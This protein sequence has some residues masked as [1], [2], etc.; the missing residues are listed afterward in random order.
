MSRRSA[1]KEEQESFRTKVLELLE[2]LKNGVAIKY[3]NAEVELLLDP[4][5]DYDIMAKRVNNSITITLYSK[6]AVCTVRARVDKDGEWKVRSA[7]CR[8]S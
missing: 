5:A 7:V 1:T 6:Y 2:R 3:E 8:R 4:S